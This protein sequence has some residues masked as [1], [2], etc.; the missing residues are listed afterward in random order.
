MS[1]L[2]QEDPDAYEPDMR[3]ADIRALVEE[4]TKTNQRHTEKAASVLLDRYRKDIEVLSTR[5]E[6]VGNMVVTLQALMTDR[7]NETK[8][9]QV[10]V[11]ALKPAPEP[12]WGDWGADPSAKEAIFATL[13][14]N[15]ITTMPPDNVLRRWLADWMIVGTP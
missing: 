11:N 3:P 8:R 10:Q 12:S 7:T 5:I 14:E 4:L 9:L 13:A 15:R 6:H 2:P 1:A